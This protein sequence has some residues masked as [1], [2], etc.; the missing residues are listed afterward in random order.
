MINE[1]NFFHGAVLTQLIHGTSQ[2]IS[3][4]SLDENENSAYVINDRIGLYIK[5][6]K[7]RLSPWTFTFLK[8]HQDTIKNLKDIYGVVIIMM[9]C[10][11]DGIVGLS[12]EE[13][14]SILDHNHED[15]EW[16]KISRSKR[17]MYQVN[18]S[19]GN[20]SFKIAREDY[21]RKYLDELIKN[22]KLD[23]NSTSLLGALKE[24]FFQA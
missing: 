15:V 1:F 18:G 21:L 3:I 10:N 16:V 14:K 12:F 24:K 9:V 6:S 23:N 8:K 19:D 4:R 22:S 2:S 7:K 11:D 13:L 17:L 5:Y 20:L